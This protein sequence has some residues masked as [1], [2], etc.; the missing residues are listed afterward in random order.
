MMDEVFSQEGMGGPDP[1]P[2]SSRGG[3]GPNPLPSSPQLDDEDSLFI[4]NVLGS[5]VGP[6]GDSSPPPPCQALSHFKLTDSP[7]SPHTKYVAY[8]KSFGKFCCNL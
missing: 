6:S 8:P 3:G 2:S 5:M 1:L 7:V 4:D